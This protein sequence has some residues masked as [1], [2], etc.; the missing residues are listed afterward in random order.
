M[1][2]LSIDLTYA[3]GAALS[4]VSV[5]LWPE[6][7]TV[8]DSAVI[9]PAPAWAVTDAYGQ[10]ILAFTPTADIDGVLY[11][12]RIGP[13]TWSGL[14]LLSDD[15]DADD[16][17]RGRHADGESDS[18]V[19][20]TLGERIA[21][22]IAKAL[23]PVNERIDALRRDLTTLQDIEGNDIGAV[24]TRISTAEAAIK[25][26][27]NAIG[28][29]HDSIRE[30]RTELEAEASTR[31]DMDTALGK[32][33]DAVRAE[34]PEFI[35][36]LVVEPAGVA[37]SF[38]IMRE[39]SLVLGERL[40]V[41]PE[42]RF[43]AVFAQNRGRDTSDEVQVVPY[44]VRLPP[45]S[46]SFTIKQ[47][48]VAAV[49]LRSQDVGL[50]MALSFLD[51]GRQVVG[52][53]AFTVPFSIGIGA[54]FGAEGERRAAGD[55]L[56]RLAFH[57][58]GSLNAQLAVHAA[59]D[60]AAL[61]VATAD[62]SGAVR[63]YKAGQSYYVA[64]H[65]TT[66]LFMVLLAEQADIPHLPPWASIT[67]V[68]AGLPSYDLPD[69]LDFVFTHRIGMHTLTGATLAI[70]G[71]TV[72]IALSPETPVGNVTDRGIL[73]FTLNDAVRRAIANN[74]RVGRVTAAQYTLTLTLAGEGDHEHRGFILVN[75]TAFRP[76]P[77][78]LAPAVAGA[79]NAGVT[80]VVLPADFAQFRNLRLDLW[81][82][83]RDRIVEATLSTAMLAAQVADTRA[84]LGTTGRQE[85][86]RIESLW[87]PG[88]RTLAVT[89]GDRIIYAA[90][91]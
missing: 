43:L 69:H 31:R 12:L 30:N 50:N 37:R 59:N 58:E 53:K 35:T 11:V 23:V 81:D 33:I 13:S 46:V 51:S 17:L 39:F 3:G 38:E 65:H 2:T 36:Q 67:P 88:N 90:L 57:S 83:G 41:P 27:L 15:I 72:G 47:E 75:D 85:A 76:I 14:E 61:L 26:N 78:M 63:D 48:N 10:A 52:D 25:A 86:H 74:L 9:P 18:A 68:P 42:T 5:G 87:T 8:S 60:D 80:S 70:Q 84:V 45:Q 44:D 6:R 20:Q 91:E 79:D 82:V 32:R 89:T 62:F 21:A 73:L 49:G 64:P 71:Q 19:S 1:P 29:N 22:D 16:L 77:L 56:Q 54:A 7:S 66:E 40:D 4:G 24:V 55:T 28:L 34:F